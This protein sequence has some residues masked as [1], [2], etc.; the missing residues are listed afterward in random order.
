MSKQNILYKEAPKMCN[1]NL[2][3]NVISQ[4]MF[5]ANNFLALPDRALIF[6][7]LKSHIDVT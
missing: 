3:F 4:I 7:K 5:E 2:Y 1:K 6:L